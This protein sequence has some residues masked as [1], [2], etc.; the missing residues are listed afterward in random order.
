LES[1]RRYTKE[2]T[3][4]KKNIVNYYPSLAGRSITSEASFEWLHK[5]PEAS[6]E[7]VANQQLEIACNK[8]NQSGSDAQAIKLCPLQHCCKVQATLQVRFDT[9]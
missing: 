5:N 9:I 7:W 4:R 3:N 1:N 2:K 8:V 6:F